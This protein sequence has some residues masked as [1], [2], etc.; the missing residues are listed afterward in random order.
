MYKSAAVIKGRKTLQSPC[1]SQNRARIAQKCQ[2]CELRHCHHPCPQD[3]GMDVW[4]LSFQLKHLFLFH[5]LRY[6]YIP[7]HFEEIIFALDIKELCSIVIYRKNQVNKPICQLPQ[8][9]LDLLLMRL[10]QLRRLLSFQV[11]LEKSG[12]HCDGWESSKDCVRWGPVWRGRP[13]W[14]KWCCQTLPN[15]I[16]RLLQVLF[17]DLALGK[18]TLQKYIAR[19]KWIS[20]SCNCN[21]QKHYLCSL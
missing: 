8:A 11:S 13:R 18:V 19:K 4:F 3:V 16:P 10:V 5:N 9:Y 14:S 15:E 17:L 20:S 2:N 7:L 12:V 6:P 1:N 21:G